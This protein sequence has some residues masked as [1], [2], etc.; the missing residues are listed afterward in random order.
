MPDYK[1]TFPK[2]PRQKLGTVVKTT[3]PLAI[4]LLEVQEREGGREEERE[5]GRKR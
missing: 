5:G 4:D 3:D 1:N 2:W